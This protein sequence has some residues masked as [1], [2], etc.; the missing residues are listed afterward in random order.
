MGLFENLD[1][2]QILEQGSIMGYFLSWDK[3]LMQN[4]TY[5]WRCRKYTNE[6]N[7]EIT[8]LSRL[9]TNGGWGNG[10]DQLLYWRMISGMKWEKNQNRVRVKKKKA[11][12]INWKERRIITVIHL[13]DYIIS[14]SPTRLFVKQQ[15]KFNSQNETADPTTSFSLFSKSNHISWIVLILPV[16]KGRSS[17]GDI[18][19]AHFTFR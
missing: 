14:E 11:V 12:G 1:H 3:N 17:Q 8:S 15:N 5:Y 16:K 10:T 7:W 9:Y 18:L 19:S 4:T 2:F 6:S 13:W